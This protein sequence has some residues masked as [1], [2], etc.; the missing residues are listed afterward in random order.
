MSAAAAAS[1]FTGAKL[2]GM[3]MPS[4]CSAQPVSVSRLDELV[5]PIRTFG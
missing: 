1:G 3:I 4:A 5:R 2:V